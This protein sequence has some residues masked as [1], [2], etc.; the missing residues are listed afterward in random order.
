MSQDVTR[1]RYSE[2]PDTGWTLRN[3]KRC[4]FRPS[5]I[6]DVGGYAG[7]WTRMAH[8]IFPE[9]KFFVIEANPEK[10]KCLKKLVAEFPGTI[11]YSIVLLGA[12]RRASVTYYQMETGSSVFE[13]QS[14]VK[15]RV[16]TLPMK[17]L[18]EAVGFRALFGPLL[19]K[20]DVQGA[21]LEVL[22]G[23]STTLK[24]TEVVLLEVSFLQ[25]NKNSPLAE[26]VIRFMNDR[27]FVVYDI[28]TLTRCGAQ[29][30]LL[31]AD[32][33]FVRPGFE[34]RPYFFKQSI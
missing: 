22:K 33:F 20:L 30:S 32:M 5:L 4:K 9:A 18:D 21:E 19:L 29:Q 7:D 28:G 13:E 8:K 3:L 15:R 6:I 23:A 10:E 24:K 34:F 1:V 11:E 26:E 25:Y 2:S 31:Q 12:E 14:D 16:I 17:T 27:G